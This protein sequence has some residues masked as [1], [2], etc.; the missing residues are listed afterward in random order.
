MRWSLLLLIGCSDV[1]WLPINKPPRPLY[2]RAAD[3]VELFTAGAPQREYVEVGMLDVSP[4][5]REAWLD[6]PR[7]VAKLRKEAGEY[8]CD[9]L[10]VNGGGRNE[11]RGTCIVYR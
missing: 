5:P 6:T 10:V 2:R 11:V 8:G 3:T 7:L 1:S 9:A 4:V